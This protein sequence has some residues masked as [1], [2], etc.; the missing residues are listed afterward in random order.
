MYSLI[1]R[2]YAA[3][4]SL[5]PTL[6]INLCN[7]QYYVPSQN[8]IVFLLSILVHLLKVTAKFTC[9]VRVVAAKPWQ[10][11]KLCSPTRKY[12]TRLTL[13]DPTARIHAFVIG[14]DGVRTNFIVINFRIYM[15]LIIYYSSVYLSTIFCVAD[16]FSAIIPYDRRL[17]LM[18]IRALQI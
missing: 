12:M 5:V 18:V 6:D 11:E 17:F 3:L 16:S 4:L 2:Y 15:F 13:E 14:E 9:V 7:D 1:Q 8:T 10:A